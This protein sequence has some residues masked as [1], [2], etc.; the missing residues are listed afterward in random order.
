MDKSVLD[1]NISLKII[2]EKAAVQVIRTSQGLF[3][4]ENIL[5]YMSVERAL[6]IEWDSSAWRAT[7]NEEL[8]KCWATEPGANP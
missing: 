5:D 6:R 7:V 8:E 2:T 3:K 1:K 4:G